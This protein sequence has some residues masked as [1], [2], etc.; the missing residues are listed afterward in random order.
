M[1]AL[2]WISEVVDAMARSN[3]ETVRAAFRDGMAMG[4]L[5]ACVV[6]CVVQIVVGPA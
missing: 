5:F 3:V 1:S 6:Y 2:D 4:V